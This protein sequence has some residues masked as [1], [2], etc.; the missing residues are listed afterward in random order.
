MDMFSDVQQTILFL[1][2]V[3]CLGASVMAVIS[4]FEKVRSRWIV[5]RQ[6]ICR[7]KAR[8]SRVH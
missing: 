8:T 3:V 5:R 6:D 7:K 1:T 2:I 4:D